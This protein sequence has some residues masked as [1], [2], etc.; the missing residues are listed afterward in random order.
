[1]IDPEYSY[2]SILYLEEEPLTE[3]ETKQLALD[4]ELR[5][6]A[7]LAESHTIQRR[8][9]DEKAGRS[10]LWRQFVIRG[11]QLEAAQHDCRMLSLMLVAAAVVVVLMTVLWI[12]K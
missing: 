3:Q 1:M 5:A 9:E 6:Q 12:T 8:L 7:Y 2:E 4:A 10:A 11:K